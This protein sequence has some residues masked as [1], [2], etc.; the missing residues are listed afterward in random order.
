MRVVVL[1]AGAMGSLVAARLARA[2]TETTL[3][4][5]PS[6]HLVAIRESGLTIEEL[7]GARRTVWLPIAERA[8]TVAGADLV[9][10]L[11]KAWATEEAVAPLRFWLGPG[12]AI[13]TLQNGLGNAAAIRA[14]LGPGALP[15]VLVGVTAQAALRLGPG[16]VRHTGAGATV[17]GR[18]DGRVDDRLV[19][20]ARLFSA[21]GIETAAVADVE[22][23]VWRKL[24]VNAAINGLTALAGVAN[25]E[26]AV[27]PE[28][29][30]AAAILAGEVAAVA[31]R[32]GL[33]LGDVVAAVDEVAR[34]TAANRSS[35]LQDVEAGRRTE[36]DAIHGAVAA[37]GEELGTPAPANRLVAAL[38]RTRERQAA[39][40]RR[41][42]AERIGTWT[43]VGEGR[44]Q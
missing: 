44:V 43:R 36:V 20:V 22:W 38:V 27:D 30:A 8:G 11:V 7:D 15:E 25:G 1:G 37:I 26:I 31:R 33:D 19:A 23:W 6:P 39:G 29:R 42:A 41:Q 32:R 34:A 10:V 40:G 18:E 5:R 16:L 2:G 24:A 12:T 17:I 35:M 14:A 9:V 28:L 21:A 4:G 13:L 3:L